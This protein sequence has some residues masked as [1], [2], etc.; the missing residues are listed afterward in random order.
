M[1]LRL[2][3]GAVRMC[4]IMPELRKEMC[5]RCGDDRELQMHAWRGQGGLSERSR[6]SSGS[7]W[8]A[9]CRRGRSGA[10]KR[11]KKKHVPLRMCG[12][13]PE[14]PPLAPTFGAPGRRSRALAAAGSG[15]ARAGGWSERRAVPSTAACRSGVSGGSDG[16]HLPPLAPRFGAPGRR[17]RDLAPVCAEVAPGRRNP[18][19]S[20]RQP[21]PGA[22]AGERVRRQPGTSPNPGFAAKSWLL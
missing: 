18:G 19:P 16:A 8:G 3:P 13:M 10:Q 17:G 12:I 14:L 1:V 15:S 11:R 6:A 22:S 5:W 9:R 4:G 20:A 7:A 2:T 21:C